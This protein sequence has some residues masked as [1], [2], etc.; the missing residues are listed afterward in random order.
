MIGQT[1]FILTTQCMQPMSHYTSTYACNLVTLLA[2]KSE[3]IFQDAIML[4]IL[5][6]IDLLSKILPSGCV[7][8]FIKRLK[9][10]VPHALLSYMGTYE[11]F[12][13]FEKCKKHLPTA[14]ASLNTSLVFLKIPMCLYILTQCARSIFYSFNFLLQ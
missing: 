13:R 2:A 10:L 12:R 1:E 3:K 8:D 6:K 14:C 11:F 7:D 9:E 5:I 4:A